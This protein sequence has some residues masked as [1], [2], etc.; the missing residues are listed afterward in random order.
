M[1]LP[2]RLTLPSGNVARLAASGPVVPRRRAPRAA[3][4][5]ETLEAL[6]QAVELERNGEAMVVRDLALSDFHVL[7]A[8]VMRGG[9]VSEPEVA[10]DCRNCNAAL[11]LV[12]CE[13]L[14]M[15]PWID[16]ELG[17]PELDATLPFGE[18]HRLAFPVLLGRV[19]RATT[20]TF[21]PRTVREALPLWAA[22]ARESL[23][24]DAAVVVAMGL[25][26]LG[27]ERDPVVIA[28]V[29]ARASEAEFASVCDLFLDSHYPARLAGV[30]FCA[31]CQARN[32]VDAPYEREFPRGAVAARVASPDDFPSF[33]VFATRAEAIGRPLLDGVPGEAVLLVVEGGTPAVDDGGEPLLGSYVPPHGGEGGLPS[34]PPTVTVYYRTFQ[35][36][37]DEDGAYDWEGEL[38]ETIEHELE[39]HVYFLRGE[40]PMDDE[41]RSEI[42]KEAVRIVG[43]REVDRRAL[44]SFGSSLSDFLRRT[45]PL[46]LIALAALVLSFAE[47]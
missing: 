29:L 25:S 3:L 19:R 24:L 9:L 7:R 46:W 11:T 32:D 37:W 38:E 6:D 30:V 4:F 21:E 44:E 14:E 1:K 28:R 33:D 47:R 42:E 26:T 16:G 23:D 10:V 18:P 40:D 45:W 31:A 35:S 22:L 36:M 15:A 17:D 5:S 34:R 20:A 8:A 43:R 13:H 27:N 2:R 41:E 39:H 12:P